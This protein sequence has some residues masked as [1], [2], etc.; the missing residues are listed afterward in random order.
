MFTPKA[1]RGRSVSGFSNRHAMPSNDPPRYRDSYEDVGGAQPDAMPA[2]GFEVGSATIYEPSNYHGFQFKAIRTKPFKEGEICLAY[3]TNGDRDDTFKAR[4]VSYNVSDGELPVYTAISH[5]W[6]GSQVIDRQDTLRK[7]WTVNHTP[8]V[9]LAMRDLLKT[10]L[11]DSYEVALWIDFICLPQY[12]ANFPRYVFASMSNVYSKCKLCIAIPMSNVTDEYE[13]DGELTSLDTIVAKIEKF[14]ASKKDDKDCDG[15]YEKSLHLD[16]LRKLV[17]EIRGKEFIT[18]DLWEAM[19]YQPYGFMKDTLLVIQIAYKVLKSPYFGRLWPFQEIMLPN[20]FQIVLCRKSDGFVTLASFEALLQIGFRAISITGLLHQN[21]LFAAASGEYI[22]AINQAKIKLIFSAYWM[23]RGREIGRISKSRV[24]AEI[25][26]SNYAQSVLQVFSSS[27]R[28]AE[29][30][31]DYVNGLLGILPVKMNELSA[32][33]LANHTAV[34]QEFLASLSRKTKRMWSLGGFL[35]QGVPEKDWY[36]SSIPDHISSSQIWSGVFC[37]GSYNPGFGGHASADTVDAKELKISGVLTV[38]VDLPKMKNGVEQYLLGCQK[39]SQHGGPKS[40]SK[41]RK[42]YDEEIE[43]MN[44]SDIIAILHQMLCRVGGSAKYSFYTMVC[45]LLQLSESNEKEPLRLEIFKFLEAEGKNKKA[46]DVTLPRSR[47]VMVVSMSPTELATLMGLQDKETPLQVSL[48]SPCGCTFV[49]PHAIFDQ[50]TFFW[51]L[52]RCEMM[53]LATLTPGNI[54]G[55]TNIRQD[56]VTMYRATICLPLFGFNDLLGNPDDDYEFKGFDM[57]ETGLLGQNKADLRPHF[58]GLR[59]RGVD[60]HF[61]KEVTGI[62]V[63][64]KKVNED[65]L[66]ESKWDKIRLVQRQ[67][68]VHAVFTNK[69]GIKSIVVKAY[70]LVQKEDYRLPRP[71]AVLTYARTPLLSLL[72]FSYSVDDEQTFVAP[73]EQSSQNPYWDKPFFPDVKEDSRIKVHIHDEK[74]DASLGLASFNMNEF[75]DLKRGGEKTL[76]RPITSASAGRVSGFV[77]LKV[78]TEVDGPLPSGSDR[79]EH[80][81]IASRNAGSRSTSWGEQMEEVPR[82]VEPLKVRKFTSRAQFSGGKNDDAKSSWEQVHRVSVD[83]EQDSPRMNLHTNTRAATWTKSRSAPLNS[84]K[85]SVGAVDE[86]HALLLRKQTEADAAFGYSLP[87]G[88]EMK[89]RMSD[90]KVYFVNLS[91][92][93]TQWVDPRAVSNIV[94]PQFGNN[95]SKMVEFIHSQPGMR[96]LPGN[97]HITI[98]KHMFVDDGY[99]EIMRQTPADLKKHLNIK[100]H[101]EDVVVEL[102]K[103]FAMLESDILHPNYGYAIIIFFSHVNAVIY[104]RLF[105]FSNNRTNLQINPNSGINPE[106]LEYFT[107]IGRMFGLGLFHRQRWK[108]VLVV[109]FYKRILRQ[110]VCLSDLELVDPDQYNEFQA[111]LNNSVG[112]SSGLYF[113]TKKEMFGVEEV[114]DLKPGGRDIVVNDGNKSD[115]VYLY[116]KWLLH[117]RIEDQFKAFTQGFNEIVHHELIAMLSP[118][119]LK[120]MINGNTSVNETFLHQAQ[121]SANIAVEEQESIPAAPSTSAGNDSSLAGSQA[122]IQSHPPVAIFHI[123]RAHLKIDKTRELGRGSFGVVYSGTWDGMAV[124][125]KYF[126]VTNTEK[127]VSTF[128]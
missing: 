93:T 27:P 103:F 47:S 25:I 55:R 99:T 53:N 19:E 117:G 127:H 39:C 51:G 58:Q 61:Y 114:V 35:P 20:R 113:S 101:G 104:D 18:E 15:L 22:L 118:E 94:A 14:M 81:D 77:V 66:G 124:A 6:M 5:L 1:Q 33:D 64:I 63:V 110:N 120:F 92:K 13:W 82:A 85:E 45:K 42:F 8:A 106:H 46:P 97:C 52:S 68:G 76:T 10:L 73:A 44:Q 60:F 119:E 105:E 123:P 122:D 89:I 111:L 108:A 80:S 57:V 90:K 31:E 67:P 16:V 48:Q 84:A 43:D 69:L 112:V 62:M 79:E 102:S 36:K 78:A 12:L 72:T 2:E 41:A 83:W 125:I 3:V 121:G 107:F 115:Y 98:R 88:W 26:D 30:P 37:A 91:T 21:G 34:I 70:D 95:F 9:A 17:L 109:S 7:S 100:F 24:Q 116:C 32:A 65:S 11:R 75:F 28:I 128:H 59:D 4:L 29:R 38:W 86:V 126:S 23:K 54:V 74:N 96:L 87:D 71:Y 56:V 49:M 40:F 50:L